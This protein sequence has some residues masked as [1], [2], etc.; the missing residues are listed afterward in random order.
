MLEVRPIKIDL[1]AD[2]GNK[3]VTDQ[4]VEIKDTGEDWRKVAEQVG[5][6]EFVP[7]SAVAGYDSPSKVPIPPWVVIRTI[8]VEKDIGNVKVNFCLLEW[9]YLR[10]N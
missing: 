9:G 7:D 4:E 8:R 10:A 2:W 6:R 3:R 5:Q 1:L